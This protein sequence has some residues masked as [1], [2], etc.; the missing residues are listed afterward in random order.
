MPG[1]VEPSP[2]PAA[3]CFAAPHQVQRIRQL[4]FT[5]GR[6][7]LQIFIISVT[8]VVFF[9]HS[10][11]VLEIATIQNCV[12]V[13]LQEGTVCEPPPP[14]RPFAHRRCAVPRTTDGL[15]QWQVSQGTRP[16]TAGPL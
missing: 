15:R 5:R 1:V 16:T 9:F 6:T 8:V 10:S 12:T 13:D 11:V 7:S 2:A 4:S 14:P 3:I